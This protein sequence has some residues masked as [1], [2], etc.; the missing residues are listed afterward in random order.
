MRRLAGCAVFAVLLLVGS[1]GGS[2]PPCCAPVPPGLVSWWP[3]N[4]SAADVVGGH[5]GTLMD[6]ATF[7]T[8]E[9]G[10]GFSLDGSNDYVSV[11]DSPAL[12]STG[13]FSLDAWVKTTGDGAIMAH[14]E[15]G[16]FCV[17]NQSNSDWELSIF[18]NH[19]AGFVRD[20]DSGGSD[21][22]G[23]GLVGNATLTDGAFHHVALVRDIA[24]NKLSLYVDG[25]LEASGDL[26]AGSNGPLGGDAG[27]DGEAD[28]VTIGV[29]INSTSAL[30]EQFAGTIDEPDYWNAALT[31]A[32]VAAIASAGPNGKCTDEVAPTSAATTPA[33][34][35]VGS[36]LTISYTASDNVGVARVNL[37]VRTPG[38]SGFSE[39]ATD[40]TGSGRFSYTPAAAGDYGFATTAEDAGCGRE[41]APADADAVTH[42]GAATVTPPPTTTPSTTP[43]QVPITQIAALP[44]AK[45]CVSRRRF[46]IHLR[47]HG[48]HPLQATV[49]L[50]GKRVKIIKGAHLAADIDLRGLPKGKV[51]VRLT[52]SYREG[53]TLTGTR[54]YHACTAHKHKATH[55]KV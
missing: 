20:Q 17:S 2:T 49:F 31:Q 43:K 35:T 28:P 16:G 11:P 29:V 7:A 6:N 44:S 41:A 13:S 5:D 32:Q 54:T 36:P 48:L 38:T 21:D 15:C 3:A 45:A 37:L 14:Y 8:G 10:Q 33:N 39:V 18:N 24:A 55:H 23:Q 22:G 19:L 25:A 27:N 4:G 52:I 26:N 34:G 51:K 42:V 50:N 46:R 12:Y 9:V 30:V 40:T 47:N 53:K 1:A